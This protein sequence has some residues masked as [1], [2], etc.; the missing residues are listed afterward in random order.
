M[1]KTAASITL[2]QQ[3]VIPTLQSHKTQKFGSSLLAN[4]VNR[5]ACL[6]NLKLHSLIVFKIRKTLPHGMD[7][8]QTYNNP[9]F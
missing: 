4:G 8:F 5:I 6:P 1:I 7:E 3:V 2:K 9:I